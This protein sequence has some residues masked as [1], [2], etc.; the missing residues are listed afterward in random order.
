MNSLLICMTMCANCALAIYFILKKIFKVYLVPEIRYILLLIVMALYLFPFTLLKYDFINLLRGVFEEERVVSVLENRVEQYINL[1][2]I[3]LIK[4]DKV[5]FLR[6]DLI[7]MLLLGIWLIILLCFSINILMRYLRLRKYVKNMEII[8]VEESDFDSKWL[9]Q[10]KKRKLTIGKMKDLKCAFTYGVISPVVVLPNNLCEKDEKILLNHELI[11]IL[12]F[13]SVIRVLNIIIVLVHFFNPLAFILLREM[14]NISELRCDKKLLKNCSYEVRK[15]YGH[16]LISMATEEKEFGAMH[17]FTINNKKIIKER[18][19]MIKNNKHCNKFILGIAIITMSLASGLPVFAYTPPT[20]TNDY[21]LF[22]D[23][24]WISMSSDEDN[25]IE[26][27]DELMFQEVDSY[28]I[29]EDGNVTEYS[30]DGIMTHSCSHLYKKAQLKKHITKIG[31]GCEIKVYS[32]EVCRI[33]S[34][35]KNRKYV[36]TI[37]YEKCIHK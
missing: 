8:N 4:K 31:G 37:T 2:K 33:C 26:G 28:I 34:S 17:Y 9:N 1:N 19:L 15:Y 12:H 23:A 30:D 21:N 24:D 10:V 27:T 32:A 29:F 5:L 18:V 13:D 16:L 11:H 3:I 25:A 22:E 36:N 20:V 14:E 7:I 35:I 6:Y